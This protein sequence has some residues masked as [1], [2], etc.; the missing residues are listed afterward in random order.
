MR[1]RKT[2]NILDS[3]LRRA[4]TTLCPRVAQTATRSVHT[5]RAAAVPGLAT[6]ASTQHW[7]ML[8]ACAVAATLGLFAWQSE[9]PAHAAPQVG[10]LE[11]SIACIARLCAGI[12]AWLPLH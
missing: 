12:G 3:M 1:I 8:G 5:A 7:G 9:H 10:T 6:G 11:P 2:V 4:A